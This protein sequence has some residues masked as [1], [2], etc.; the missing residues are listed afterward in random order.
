MTV[1]CLEKNYI[2]KCYFGNGADPLIIRFNFRV[3]I[4][5]HHSLTNQG[6]WLAF[7]RRSSHVSYL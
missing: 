1:V 4:N 3:S 7:T 5:K 2:V 6:E